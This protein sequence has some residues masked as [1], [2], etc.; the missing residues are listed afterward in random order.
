MTGGIEFEPK[1]SQTQLTH[2]FSENRSCLPAILGPPIWR[3][4]NHVRIESLHYTLTYQR[5]IW[6]TFTQG[7][8]TLKLMLQ[9]RFP[10]GIMNEV[11][12]SQVSCQSSNTHCLPLIA[13]RTGRSCTGPLPCRSLPL[14]WHSYLLPG[15]FLLPSLGGRTNND[16]D[17]TQ[18][19][20]WRFP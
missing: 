11:K 2:R 14:L 7:Y 16:N 12:L 4:P 10:R 15:R 3:E 17:V 13:W 18:L 8:Y 9:A 5:S 19:R 20:H 6:F 1:N